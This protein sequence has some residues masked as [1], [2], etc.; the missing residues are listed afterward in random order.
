MGK[1]SFKDSISIIFNTIKKHDSEILT[2]VGIAGMITGTVL[3][4]KTTPKVIKLL[5]EE[6]AN[7]K[8][9]KLEIKDTIK[10]AWK[11]YVPVAGIEFLAALCLVEAQVSQSK[12]NAALAVAYGLSETA[13]K[14]YQEK[15]IE[16]FG[17][18]KEGEVRDALAKEKVKNSPVEKSEII[19]TKKGQ[20]LCYDSLSGRYFKS[21]IEAVRK[22]ENEINKILLNEDYV[23]L[24]EFYGVLGLD[25]IEIGRSLGWNINDGYIELHFSSQLATDETPCLVIGYRT[26]PYYFFESRP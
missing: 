11:Y 12:R 8:A 7:Q 21:D 23:N 26:P 22:A 15:V 25:E 13:L 4:V 17:E 1:K 18:K 5:E 3:A 14:E 9:D 16:T 10:M 19:F 6:K 20:T 2:G 24:N